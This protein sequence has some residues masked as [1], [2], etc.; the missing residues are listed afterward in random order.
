[1]T[2]GFC[3]QYYPLDSL[4]EASFFSLFAADGS[5]LPEDIPDDMR[6]AAPHLTSPHIVFSMGEMINYIRF[7]EGLH[8]ASFGDGSTEQA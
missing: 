4:E 6:S 2:L 1:M 5:C 7:R 3:V 8:A